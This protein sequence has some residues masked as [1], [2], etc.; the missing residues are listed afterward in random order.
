MAVT[1]YKRQRQIVDF[2][3]QYIQKNGF[4][5]TLR[6]IAESI[7]VSSLATVHEHLQALQR[8][9]V[10][11]RHEGAVRGIELI[12]RTFMRISDSVD[13]P[14]LGYIAAG[15]P[16][17]P[18]TDSAASFKVSPEM[19]SGKKRSYVLQVKGKSMIEDHIDDGDYVVIEETQAV[20]D[21]DIVVALLDNGLATLKRFYKELTRVRLE[22]A[23]SSMSP[24]YATNVQIQGRVVGL[25][26][27][28]Q[29]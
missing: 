2:I 15:S 14:L 27:K 17:E 10:I 4:S 11:K 21:G 22:P 29:Y 26:R 24:I 23:N 25:I 5:P 8:K 13:L 16:I 7:G 6:E 1:L 20:S 3:A 28:F 19:I 9:K 18:H 12:D